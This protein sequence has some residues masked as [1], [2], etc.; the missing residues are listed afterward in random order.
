MVKNEIESNTLEYISTEKR[1]NQKSWVQVVH[2]S[3]DSVALHFIRNRES[4]CTSNYFVSRQVHVARN[5]WKLVSV[6]YVK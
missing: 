6:M 3:Q 2:T 1:E 5:D 4:S